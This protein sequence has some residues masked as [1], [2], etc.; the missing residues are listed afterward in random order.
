MLR[1]KFLAERLKGR[2]A[3][4]KLIY[5]DHMGYD[6][7][8]YDA[9]NPIIRGGQPVSELEYLTDAFTREGTEFI[10]RHADKPFFLFMAYNAVHSPLQG[11]DTYMQRF[12]SIPD[13]HRRIF[14]AMLA[15]LDDSVGAILKQLDDLKLANNTLVIFLSDNG[16][17]TRELTSSN[18]PLRGGKG[19]MYEGGL[20]VPFIL[21]WPG[22]VAQST[23]YESAIS[24]LDILPTALAAAGGK[25]LGKRI[26]GVDLLPYLTEETEAPPHQQF[27]WRQGKRTALRDQDWKLIGGHSKDWELYQIANDLTES[28]NLATEEPERLARMIESWQAYE[29]EM[30]EPVFG[31]R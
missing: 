19:Q 11:A 4:E 24:S 29:E 3:S 1:R 18:L 31:K 14:A 27:Y 22:K 25:P 21:R 13:I 9:N 8:D 30:V 26:D 6:E 20:R 5:T 17:P 7:P 10:Q 16:G 28:N 15:N 12:E 2:W 23:L